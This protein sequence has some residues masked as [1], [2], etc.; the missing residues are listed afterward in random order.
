MSSQT[1]RSP[2]PAGSRAPKDVWNDALKNLKKTEPAIYGP[3]SRAKYGGFQNGVYRALF[4]PG[5]EIFMTMLSAPERKSKIENALNQAGGDHAVFEALPQ[6]MPAGAD[7]DA[8]KRQE[9]S[10]NDLIDMF[11]RNKVQIDE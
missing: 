4:G 3:L 9:K 7:A 8:E 5:E 11:G 10:L 6:M 2:V 1:S